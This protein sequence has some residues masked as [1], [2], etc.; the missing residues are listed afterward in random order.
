[1]A[2]HVELIVGAA[3]P[4]AAHRFRSQGP[5][6]LH[7]ATLRRMTGRLPDDGGVTTT[8]VWFGDPDR[9]L[10]GWFEDPSDGMARAGVVVC[11]PLAV[12]G[13]SSQPTL[14][15]LSTRLAAEAARYCDSTTPGQAT[16]PETTVN[17]AVLPPGWRASDLPSDSSNRRDVLMSHSW[18]SV[19]GRPLPRPNY[20][21]EAELPLPFCGIPIRPGAHS[22]A[23]KEYWQRSR[24]WAGKG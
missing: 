12:E 8:P 17:Q 4:V 5:S 10:F 9:P 24:R 13:T 3:R 11:P 23:N 6:M 2:A 7:E 15:F 14:R 21:Q 22:F 16:R 20:R 19:W 1:M 18:V